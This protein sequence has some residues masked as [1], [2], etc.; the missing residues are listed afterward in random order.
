MPSIDLSQVAYSLQYLLSEPNPA[1]P[2]NEEAANL[3]LLDPKEFQK[4]VNS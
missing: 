2:L 4:R 1:D 3:L